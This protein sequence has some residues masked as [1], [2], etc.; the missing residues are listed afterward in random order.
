M[1]P[2]AHLFLTTNLHSSQ[3]LDSK[4]NNTVETGLTISAAVLE[5]WLILGAGAHR[6]S[7]ASM[8]SKSSV[9]IDSV[10]SLY[11]EGINRSC[12]IAEI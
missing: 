10:P 6:L 11:L 1:N 3:C 5:H 9:K 2:F 8:R 7:N 4:S 12:Y